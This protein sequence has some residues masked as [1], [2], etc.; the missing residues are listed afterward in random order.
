M[1]HYKQ[2][3]RTLFHF[4]AV[5]IV[6]YLHW[7]VFESIV[8][9]QLSLS[10]AQTAAGKSEYIAKRMSASR[11]DTGY[12]IVKVAS[13]VCATENGCPIILNTEQKI[14]RF[15]KIDLVNM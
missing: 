4:A 8:V 5:A 6:N 13:A 14:V 7:G 2:N 1:L 3:T 15:P 9:V 12:Q 11:V 10:R